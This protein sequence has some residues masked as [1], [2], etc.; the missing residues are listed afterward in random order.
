MI[1]HDPKNCNQK[2][3]TCYYLISVHFPD[4]STVPLRTSFQVSSSLYSQQAIF[5]DQDYRNIILQGQYFYY[6]LNPGNTDGFSFLDSLEIN[7]ETIRGDADLVVS[8]T[9]PQ[10]KIEGNLDS[11]FI[12]SSRQ[13][14]RFEQIRLQRAKNFTLNRTIYIGVY[15][16]SLSVY[17]LSFNPTYTTNFQSKLSKA[18]PLNDTQPYPVFFKQEWDE[19]FFSFK[20]WWSAQENRTIVFVA[21]VI[22]NNIFFYCKAND[23][24]QFY[25]TEFQDK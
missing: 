7:L 2:G 11:N 1:N 15:A 17:Y 23:F 20:P 4:A 12:W 9:V 24:P 18:L 14:D 22:F 8:T 25:A 16:S 21:D 6:Q 10:P 19:A 3:F 5:M 13:S